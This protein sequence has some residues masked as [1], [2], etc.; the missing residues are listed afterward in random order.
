MNSVSVF[1][2]LHLL[3]VYLTPIQDFDLLIITLSL[4]TRWVLFVFVLSGVHASVYDRGYASIDV[5]E[6]ALLFIHLELYLL[7]TLLF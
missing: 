5:Q 2:R 7:I 3:V 4:S 1:V 6:I